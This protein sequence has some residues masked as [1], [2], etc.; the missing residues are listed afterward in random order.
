MRRAH[1]REGRRL[2]RFFAVGIVV[3]FALGSACSSDSDAGASPTPLE[4][5][6]AAPT[7]LVGSAAPT[8]NP[9]ALNEGRNFGYIKSFDTGGRTLS[10]DLA[11]FLTGEA[12]DQAA[13]QD[14]QIEPGG[15]V[16]NDYY[17]R[18][19]NKKLRTV[20]Y[21]TGVK[22]RVVNWAD[23]CDLIDGEPEPFAAGFQSGAD[24]TGEYHGP[25]SGYWLTIS[26]GTITLI[27]EQYVP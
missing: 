3:A 24:N 11:E 2:R 13:A 1:P 7:E 10:F 25:T 19:A 26:A 4:T 23:C 18:N 6:S 8:A 21:A 22:I 15:H 20:P 14:G 16:D 9:N 5:S 17:V 27:E 12:A